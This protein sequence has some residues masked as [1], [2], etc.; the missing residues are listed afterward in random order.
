VSFQNAA[1]A[2]TWVILPGALHLSFKPVKKRIEV[3]PIR[4]TQ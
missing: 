4:S 1:G 2:F 3:G